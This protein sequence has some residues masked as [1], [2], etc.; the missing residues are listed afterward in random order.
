MSVV[1]KKSIDLGYFGKIVCPAGQE[2]FLVEPS[3]LLRP[4]EKYRLN[5]PRSLT[6]F[7]VDIREH[8]LTS[9]M[10][11]T[12]SDRVRCGLN[13]NLIYRVS[14]SRR[15]LSR[16]EPSDA[17]TELKNIINTA[18]RE[19][20]QS[21]SSTKLNIPFDKIIL[22]ESRK[23][24]SDFGIEIHEIT[25]VSFHFDV[26]YF[27]DR[28]EMMHSRVSRVQ[29]IWEGIRDKVKPIDLRLDVAAPYAVPVEHVFELAVAVKLPDSP[30]LSEENLQQSKTSDV[31]LTWPKSQTAIELVIEVHS[32]DCLV[33]GNQHILFLL[34]RDRNS[35][36]FYFQLTPKHPRSLSIVVVLYHERHGLGSV[37]LTVLSE[38][39]VEEDRIKVQTQSAH[40]QIKKGKG[41]LD[42]GE[43]QFIEEKITILVRRMRELEKQRS[44]YGINTDPRV[45]MEI[46]DIRRDIDEIS[47]RIEYINDR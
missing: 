8:E 24:S 11:F 45:L 17:I 40:I 44:Y 20:L 16:P 33:Y 30:L 38:E 15:L 19:S 29:D 6:A 27:L 22:D 13:F 10:S 28:M 46:E 34:H 36:V 32:P 3:V 12:T 1:L 41:I 4:G 2:I 35:P 37:R 23:Y 39:I 21:Y 43:S 5:K 9:S 42:E 14:N 18:L 25:R 47:S 26:H 7:I 31:Y